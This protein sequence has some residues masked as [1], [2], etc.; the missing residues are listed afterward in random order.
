MKTIFPTNVL[1]SAV[2]LA[3]QEAIFAGRSET[4]IR[5]TWEPG[6]AT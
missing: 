2:M 4:E 6:L 3:I 1:V 5:K